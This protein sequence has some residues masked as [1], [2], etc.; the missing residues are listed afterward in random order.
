MYEVSSSIIHQFNFVNQQIITEG[1]ICATCIL[2]FWN[3]RG[4]CSLEEKIEEKKE[5]QAGSL[6]T[7]VFMVGGLD[8]HLWRK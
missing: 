5:K 1:L 8:R 3:S 7:T 4:I 2:G 6:N